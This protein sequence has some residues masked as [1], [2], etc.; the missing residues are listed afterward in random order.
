MDG[1]TGERFVGTIR[2]V[3]PAGDLVV[4][5]GSGIRRYLFKEIEYVIGTQPDGRN[6]SEGM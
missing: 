2:D 3:L 4:E 1:R 6:F 5:T